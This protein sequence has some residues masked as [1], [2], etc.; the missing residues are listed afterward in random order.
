MIYFIYSDEEKPEPQTLIN[1]NPKADPLKE[2]QDTEKPSPAQAQPQQ[3][4]GQSLGAG[5]EGR[6]EEKIAQFSTTTGEIGTDAES[7]EKDKDFETFT[8]W[9]QK[10]LAEEQEKN[11]VSGKEGGS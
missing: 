7:G 2:V 9:R 10:T 3:P 8:E 5:Q 11:K 1:A 6:A 4:T